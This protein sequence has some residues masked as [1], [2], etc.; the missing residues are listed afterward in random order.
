MKLKSKL[1]RNRK[2]VLR[3]VIF[4]LLTTSF[5]LLFGTQNL[6][7][8][9]AQ[10]LYLSP[11]QTVITEPLPLAITK[12]KP[13]PDLTTTHFKEVIIVVEQKEEKREEIQAIQQ[14]TRTA[15]ENH[16][17]GAITDLIYHYA[18]VYN[19]DKEQFYA[20]AYCESTLKPH[21]TSG[22]YGGLY[23]FSPSTWVSNRNSMGE[24]PDIELRFDPEQAIKTAAYKISRDGT[25]A[26]PVCQYR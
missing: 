19:I 15:I 21:A 4:T 1:F 25:G 12:P 10:D 9:D 13:S 18:E 6:G 5:T 23:Q 7:V 11:S 20:I 14:T 8:A 3:L 16:E 24:D 26:W 22:I 17:P 2:R